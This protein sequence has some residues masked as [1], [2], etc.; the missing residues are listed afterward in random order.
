MYEYADDIWEVIDTYSDPYTEE[1]LSVMFK[2]A[3][4]IV[5]KEIDY[6]L[7]SFNDMSYEDE[8]FVDD[9]YYSILDHYNY[10]KEI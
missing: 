2:E 3:E 1:E 9:S 4:H 5:S 6:M 8:C 10:N 7:F